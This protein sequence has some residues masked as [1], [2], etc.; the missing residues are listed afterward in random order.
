MLSTGSLPDMIQRRSTADFLRCFHFRIP[1]I[2][3]DI[4][5]LLQIRI[6]CNG[7]ARQI[8]PAA[9][10]PHFRAENLL[11]S[12]SMSPFIKKNHLRRSPVLAT[13]R[14][15]VYHIYIVGFCLRRYAMNGIKGHIS[16][17]EA[18]CRRAC[19]PM[20]CA[21]ALPGNA[22]QAADP[23]RAKNGKTIRR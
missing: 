9:Q 2:W 8:Q 6:R 20:L 22:A 4:N 15:F 12:V 19:Q 16:I 7:I 14:K 3:P 23:C 21:W 17:R 11:V 10:H 18:F 13:I 5:G 1:D